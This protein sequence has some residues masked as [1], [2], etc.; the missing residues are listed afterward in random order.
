MWRYNDKSNK[1]LKPVKS[2]IECKKLSIFWIWIWRFLFD[3]RGQ[4]GEKTGLCKSYFRNNESFRKGRH[5]CERML[6]I[7]CFLKVVQNTIS[8]KKTSKNSQFN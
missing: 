1:R 6:R 4:F 5:L 2:E 7:T 3:I 8:Q